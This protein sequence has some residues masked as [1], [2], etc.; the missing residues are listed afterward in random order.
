MYEVL[1]KSRS[2]ILEQLTITGL[3]I[4]L[5]CLLAVQPGTYHFLCFCFLN[6]ETG[7]LIIAFSSWVIMGLK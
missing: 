6:Y 7:I 1:E 2:R 3:N 4:D 5:T